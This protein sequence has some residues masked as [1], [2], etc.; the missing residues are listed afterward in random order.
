[1][2]RKSLALA[3]VA[4]SAVACPAFA[5]EES[6]AALRAL[7]VDPSE[8]TPEG[9]ANSAV[10]AA[11]AVAPAPAAEITPL[12]V[13]S[14]KVPLP[15]TGVKT[16]A[17]EIADLP[18]GEDAVRLQIFLDQSN[19]G[20][21][22]IDGKPGRF[23]V[24]AVDSWNEVHGHAPGDL[25]PVMEAARK[26]V[27]HPFATAQVPK[28]A[29]KWVNSGLSHDHAEQAKA[30]QMSYRSVAEFMSERFHTDVEFLLEINGAKN[31]WS[32]KPGEGSLIVPN[33]KPFVIESITGKRYEAD[34]KMSERHAVVDTKK[35]QVRIFEGAPP[36]LIVDEEEE[37]S[38][39]PVLVKAKHE[40][41]TA[42][43]ASFPITPGKPQFIHL[44]VWKL[45]NSVELPV[46]RFDK[47]LLETGKRSNDALN[48]PSG[49][50]SPVGIIWNG[51][52]KPGIGL[53]GTADPET[54][55]RAR[56]AGCV[57]LANWDAI[58]IPTL[59]R[60]GATVELR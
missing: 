14:V 43:V 19:F 37:G 34:P 51:L 3:L 38:T 4:S 11:P 16:D 27:P 30:K 10:P 57:R 48:I 46:W 47:S 1:M 59:I 25:G 18:K 36:A 7:P 8:I 13:G 39:K 12:P 21:G 5:A 2:F 41:N 53:H 58:R 49:P 50:N 31:T 17:P 28:L 20:P 22:I 42:L 40:P 33:V 60:P 29:T 44:G 54:I 52:S 15:K 26:T 55:G 9:K 35:N 23:T 45:N 24:Q 6:K 32:V 56:S